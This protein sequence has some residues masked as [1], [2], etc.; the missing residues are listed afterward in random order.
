MFIICVS[1][2]TFAVLQYRNSASFESHLN[3]LSCL[4]TVDSEVCVCVIFSCIYTFNF[5][6]STKWKGRGGELS[7]QQSIWLLVSCGFVFFYEGR[8]RSQLDFSS[9]MCLK[10]FI[11]M[12]YFSPAPL[13]PPRL[14]KRNLRRTLPNSQQQRQTTLQPRTFPRRIPRHLHKPWIHHRP[15]SIPNPC[16]ARPFSHR[17]RQL[18]HPRAPR[19]LLPRLPNSGHAWHLP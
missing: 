5:C 9:K 15:L 19:P 13:A 16:L 1:G 17:Y 12:P 6:I 7:G 8:A 4:K 10:Y 18:K 3:F 14:S 11:L 2:V